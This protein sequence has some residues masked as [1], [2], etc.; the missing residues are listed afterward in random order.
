MTIYDLVPSHLRSGGPIRPGEADGSSRKEGPKGVAAAERGDKVEI[1]QE[2][3]AMASRSRLAEEAGGG[4]APERLE[5]IQR[6]MD[7]GTYDSPEVAEEVAR[8]LIRA[9]DLDG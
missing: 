7:D 5:E 2:G 9:G 1:S 4:L 6:R 3:R 8:Q